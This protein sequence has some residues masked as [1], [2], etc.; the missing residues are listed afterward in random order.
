MDGSRGGAG[1]DGIDRRGRRQAQDEGGAAR[2]AELA[3]RVIDECA[4]IRSSGQTLSNALEVVMMEACQLSV[5]AT[6]TSDLLE[7][8]QAAGEVVLGA[9][10]EM[11]SL[12]D[13]AR[14]EAE[15]AQSRAQDGVKSVENLVQTFGTIGGFLGSIKKI[16]GQTNL[17]SLNARI[18]AARAGAHGAGFAVIAQE[19]KALAG[20]TGSLSAEIEARLAELI[21]ATRSTQS[22]F[23]AIV[24]A[25]NGAVAKLAELV[26][27]QGTVAV[28]LS[29]ERQ[30][31]AQAVAMMASVNEAMERMQAA[32]GETGAA[33]TQLTSSLDTLTVSAGGVARSE[34]S[35]LIDAVVGT[36]IATPAVAA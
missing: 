6:E 10:R 11:A 29:D 33:Y 28:T 27:R 36:R 25:V 3:G 24:A 31:A 21:A 12:A 2:L 7:R 34:D 18:E 13:T 17:L 26:A 20:E 15:Q 35:G 9:T 16:A 30:Q 5:S 32:I 23:Q 19:V 4:L 1:W 14:G 22:D 8:S